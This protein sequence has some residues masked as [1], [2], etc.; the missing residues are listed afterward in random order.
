MSIANFSNLLK[1]ECESERMKYSTLF[2]A[3]LLYAGYIPNP[4][5]SGEFDYIMERCPSLLKNKFKSEKQAK[6]LL[7]RA[8][9]NPNVSNFREIIWSCRNPS[10]E[11]T[12]TT[13][14][15]FGDIEKITAREF[16]SSKTSKYNT[17]SR[18]S[19]VCKYPQCGKE[20]PKTSK[21]CTC[22]IVHYCGRECQ[23]SHWPGKRS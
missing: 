19:F 2:R 7:G 8:V 9:E 17:R 10:C 1:Q 11:H 22:H 21:G 4:L 6:K 14:K 18:E 20:I 15:P 23:V 5:F 12:I 16:L 13:F 3:L